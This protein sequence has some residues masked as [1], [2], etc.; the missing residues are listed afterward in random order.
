M[1]KIKGK[2]VKKKKVPKG[3]SAYQAAWIVESDE[4]VAG[5]MVA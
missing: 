3:T 5:V 1:E 4:E 2:S